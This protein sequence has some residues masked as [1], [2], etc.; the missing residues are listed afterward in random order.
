M[1]SGVAGP[2]FLLSTQSPD[3]EVLCASRGQGTCEL[4]AGEGL[5]VGCSVWE[6]GAY[7]GK[8]G[9]LGSLSGFKETPI[10]KQKLQS[11]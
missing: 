2:H 5:P 6:V 7:I 11:I 3:Q 8:S 10:V 4:G 1:A 9:S